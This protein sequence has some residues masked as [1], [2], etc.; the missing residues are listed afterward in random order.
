MLTC[1][2]GCL[3]RPYSSY[4]FGLKE[5]NFSNGKILGMTVSELQL[6]DTEPLPHSSNPITMTISHF[7][8]FKSWPCPYGGGKTDPALVEMEVNIDTIMCKVQ[9]LSLSVHLGQ[10][11]TLWRMTDPT[12][13]I[14]G[15]RLL[16]K[17]IHYLQSLNPNRGE[18]G[19]S[20][21]RDIPFSVEAQSAYPSISKNV[22]KHLIIS[23]CNTFLKITASELTLT[24][25][26]KDSLTWSHPR[27]ER[28]LL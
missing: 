20:Q 18:C 5:P 24:P 3:K 15:Q 1:W 13:F 27:L 9:L 19:R 16:R 10:N 6:L 4:S 11:Q 23:V 8:C 22:P 21:P 14:S 25:L 2:I 26:T 17:G 12:P 7:M 28:A